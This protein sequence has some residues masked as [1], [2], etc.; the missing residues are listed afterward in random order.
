MRSARS[1][2]VPCEMT[3]LPEYTSTWRC[4]ST[5]PERSASTTIGL[6]RSAFSARDGSI[7]AASTVAS[8]TVDRRG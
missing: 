3:T 4:R 2:S 8:S 7:G 6:L 1:I 5:L